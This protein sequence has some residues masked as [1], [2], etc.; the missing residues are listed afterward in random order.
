MLALNQRL[1]YQAQCCLQ[2][3]QIRAPLSLH[4]LHLPFLKVQKVTIRY[5]GMGYDTNLRTATAIAFKPSEAYA[6]LKSVP[7]DRRTDTEQI[8][9]IVD[10]LQFQSTLAYLKNPPSSYPLPAVD[11]IGGL[12]NIKTSIA[13]GEYTNEYDIEVGNF[14]MVFLY[15]YPE[16]RN[17]H[18]QLRPYWPLSSP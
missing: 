15:R 11:L 7:Y 6:C 9:W 16:T 2:K 3:L 14:A 1:L 12:N 5:R 8:E 13:S 17:P 10:A 18:T 4:A